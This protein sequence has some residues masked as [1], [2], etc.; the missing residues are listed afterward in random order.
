MDSYFYNSANN[1]SFFFEGERNDSMNLQSE[2]FTQG[3]EVLHRW[4]DWFLVYFYVREMSSNS[5]CNFEKTN[6]IFSWIFC[7]E[8]A[9]DENRNLKQPKELSINKVGHGKASCIICSL[10]Q[11]GSSLFSSVVLT[12]FFLFQPVLVILRCRLFGVCSNAWSGPWI[13]QVFKVSKSIGHSSLTW[14]QETCAH[15][16]YVHF[17]GTMSE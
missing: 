15:S 6:V 3:L 10:V 16:I 1:I 13:P 14:V 4:E 5:S 9:F 11:L 8:R 12:Q 7:T 2:W 17:Q